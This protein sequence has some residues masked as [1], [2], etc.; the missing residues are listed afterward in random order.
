MKKKVR[1]QKSEIA[2]WKTMKKKI[3]KKTYNYMVLLRKREKKIMNQI[4]KFKELKC[5][6][7]LNR[8]Q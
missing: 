3:M 4:G 2:Q 5:E 7:S 8:N 6:K 1:L